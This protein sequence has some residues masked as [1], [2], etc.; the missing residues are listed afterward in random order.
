MTA[1]PDNPPEKPAFDASQ[2][3]IVFDGVCVLCSG[4]V[5]MVVGLDRISRF[6]F[7]T[8]QSPLGD[9]LFRNT[10]C[11]RTATRPIWPSSTAPP[12]P[13]WTGSLPPWP[14]GAGGGGRRSRC[15]CCRARSATGS[16]IALPRT[17]TRCSAGKRVARSL[18]PSW[19]GG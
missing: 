8:A 2:P 15:S 5:R 3:L 9:A 7:A 4:F 13:A 11:G 12:S 19:R 16:T 1:Q 6:R 10:D 17:V 14:N 18:P